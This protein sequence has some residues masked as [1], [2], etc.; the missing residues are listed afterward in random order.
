MYVDVGCGC[1]TVQDAGSEQSSRKCLC[2]CLC[3]CLSHLSMYQVLV[4]DSE[5]RRKAILADFEDEQ[6]R[7]ANVLAMERKR[8]AAELSK[9]VQEKNA[10][11]CWVTCCCW[12]S[13]A[14][15]PAGFV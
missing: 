8:Q 9:R 4:D 15:T 3:L 2:L 6:A 1:A 12:S 11:S 10:G 13:S 14:L 5:A 7:L